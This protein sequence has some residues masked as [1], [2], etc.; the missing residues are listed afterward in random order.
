MNVSQVHGNKARR[1]KLIHTH[2]EKVLHI[3]CKYCV[4]ARAMVEVSSPTPS[5]TSHALQP[6]SGKSWVESVTE[7][8]GG[9]PFSWMVPSEVCI[10]P[11]SDEGR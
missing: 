6:P 5:N 9:P 4:S 3:A 2:V 7:A 1:D 11:A 8:T 10:V